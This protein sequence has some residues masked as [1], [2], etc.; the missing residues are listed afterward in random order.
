MFNVILDTGSPDLWLADTSCLGCLPSMP[1][2]LPSQS[3]SFQGTGQQGN[4]SLGQSVTIPYGGGV[5]A[6]VTVADTVT[7]GGLEI[8]SQTFRACD[9]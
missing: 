7:M 2:F 6:G 8:A 9:F 1:R 3:S 4:I 5:V